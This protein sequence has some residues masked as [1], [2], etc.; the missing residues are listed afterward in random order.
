MSRKYT[1][2]GSLVAFGLWVGVLGGFTA[3]H[4]PKTAEPKS[5][6][7]AAGAASR[8]TLPD[9]T[10]AAK[11][12]EQSVRIGYMLSRDMHYDIKP[13]SLLKEFIAEF[14]DGT[15]IDRVS[16]SPIQDTPR[17]K[18]VYY[19]VGMGQFNGQFRAMAL[20]L[21]ESADDH[22][23]YLKP[24]ASRHI[25]QGF[26]CAFCY[27]RFSRGKVTGVECSEASTGTTERRCSFKVEPLNHFFVN[28]KK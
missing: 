3:C 14:G 6:E 24:T 17:D 16:V 19:L 5:A 23:L 22:G 18:P 1:L 2:D 8:P 28:A 7:S 11:P 12:V 20:A 21:Y 15:V 26:N 27:F 13:E 4:T 9:S 10:Q 25:A